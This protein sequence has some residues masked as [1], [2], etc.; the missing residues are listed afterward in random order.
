MIGNAELVIHTKS[1]SFSIKQVEKMLGVP[2]G[3]ELTDVW[4]ED[5]RVCFT[6]KN[7]IKQINVRQVGE[8]LSKSFDLL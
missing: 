7:A 1:Y 8:V 5:E 3:W 2:K 4:H 6:I